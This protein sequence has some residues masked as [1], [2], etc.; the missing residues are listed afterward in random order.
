MQFAR[1]GMAHAHCSM[2][3]GKPFP[4][5]RGPPECR[6]PERSAQMPTDRLRRKN[7]RQRHRFSSESGPER[8]AEFGETNSEPQGGRSDGS[9]VEGVVKSAPALDEPSFA[10]TLNDPSC[11]KLDRRSGTPLRWPA[12]GHRMLGIRIP[13]INL[14][15]LG[16]IRP[17]PTMGRNTKR[18]KY[19]TTWCGDSGCR[20]SG[21]SRRP[22]E[23]LWPQVVDILC[24]LTRSSKERHRKRALLVTTPLD[25][26]FENDL[27]F[28]RTTSASSPEIEP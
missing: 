13:H 12:E 3:H 6:G 7:Q 4:C 24:D 28:M 1:E 9:V 23:G 27:L 8:L 20:G 22:A 15:N 2:T 21:G 26:T 10:G 5:W 16:Q 18:P 17:T 25:D 19:C 14:C 11:R